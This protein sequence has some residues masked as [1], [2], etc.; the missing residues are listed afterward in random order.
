MGQLSGQGPDIRVYSTPR[1][2]GM[3]AMEMQEDQ[4]GNFG[5]SGTCSTEIQ[6]TQKSGDLKVENLLS[7]PESY[8]GSSI[9]V[10]S[11]DR[12]RVNIGPDLYNTQFMLESPCTSSGSWTPLAM[13]GFA[14]PHQK[15]KIKQL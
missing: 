14:S 13:M 11:S 2:K 5:T 7:S 3:Y 15:N 10:G 6:M 4:S 1:L 8:P 12:T 9:T